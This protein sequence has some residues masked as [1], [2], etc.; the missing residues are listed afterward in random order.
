MKANTY[1]HAS[2]LPKAE[3]CLP[4][5]SNPKEGGPAFG[6]DTRQ[7]ESQ[8]IPIKSDCPI[9]IAH[10]EMDFEQVSDGSEGFRSHIYKMRR[11]PDSNKHAT[12]K[13]S[14]RN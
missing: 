13:V 4:R 2:R 7:R 9:K 5:S 3:H 10:G 14:L 6:K 1:R 11:R 12:R 8:Q